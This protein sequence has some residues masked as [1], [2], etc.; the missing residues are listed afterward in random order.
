MNQSRRERFLAERVEEDALAA[1]GR[2]GAAVLR[3]FAAGSRI[4]ALPNPHAG[5]HCVR[6]LRADVVGLVAGSER[7]RQQVSLVVVIGELEPDQRQV[8][9]GTIVG[10]RR[11]L[12]NRRRIG[13][14]APLLIPATTEEVGRQHFF[15]SRLAVAT[16]AGGS[17]AVRFGSRLNQ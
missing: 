12:L 9:D 11:R 3:H 7:Q 17:C 2:A 5:H 15:E 16:S 10:Q 13:E 14:N 4:P 6:Q 8:G 1:D